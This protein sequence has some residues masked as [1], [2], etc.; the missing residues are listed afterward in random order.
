M[1]TPI[2]DFSKIPATE[3]SN[4]L[5]LMN[6]S[7]AYVSGVQVKLDDIPIHVTI[8]RY[9]YKLRGVNLIK[10]SDINVESIGHYESYCYRESTNRW[11]LYDDMRNNPVKCKANTNVNAE[12]IIY[13]I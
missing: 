8:K 11:E 13:T 7:E 6:D 3:K 5:P 2:I 4:S 9:V 10:P 12:M 1:T